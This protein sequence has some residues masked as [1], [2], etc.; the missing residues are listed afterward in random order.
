VFL[1]PRKPFFRWN[2][3]FCFPELETGFPCEGECAFGCFLG[4]FVSGA[5]F[6]GENRQTIARSFTL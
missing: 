1:Q 3:G 4:S 2:K 5:D 6:G